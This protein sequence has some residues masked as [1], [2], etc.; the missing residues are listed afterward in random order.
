MYNKDLETWQSFFSLGRYTVEASPGGRRCIFTAD[1][2]NIRAI[3][4][5]QFHDYGKGE[6]FHRDWEDFLGDSIFVTDLDQWHSSRQLIRPQFAKDRLSD[7][8]VFEK[9]VQIL[10]KLIASGGVSDTDRAVTD[11][12]GQEIN[13]SDMFFRYTLDTAMEFLLGSSIGS[14]KTPRQEFAEAF[15]DVQRVQNLITR[16]G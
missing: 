10:I 6:P 13:V 8:K 11:G 5:T 3:L 4:A 7:L 2:E 12:L 1:P 9:N 16:A 15:S 14:L